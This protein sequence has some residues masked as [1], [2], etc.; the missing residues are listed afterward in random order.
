MFKKRFIVNLLCDLIRFL[1]MLA[2]IS[3]FNLFL[4]AVQFSSV[5]FSSVQFGSVQ[6]GSVQFSSVQFSAVQFSS[7]QFSAVQFSSVQCSAVQCS[8]VQFSSVQFSSVQFKV[9]L[10]ARESPLA[11]PLAPRSLRPEFPHC[12][13]FD[14]VEFQR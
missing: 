1:D 9:F 12:C 2:V 3:V 4:S 13:G 8:A 7:V 11:A 6:F 5:Q 10:S 14:T